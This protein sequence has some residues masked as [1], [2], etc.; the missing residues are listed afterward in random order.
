MQ[1]A[2]RIRELAASAALFAAV[3]ALIGGPLLWGASRHLP[4]VPADLPPSTQ[5]LVRAVDKRPFT[6]DAPVSQDW[7]KASP[8]VTVFCFSGGRS[9][10]TSEGWLLADDLLLS[11]HTQQLWQIPW[12]LCVFRRDPNPGVVTLEVAEIPVET[13]TT[14]PEGP[15]TTLAHPE[16]PGAPH[17]H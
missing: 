12:E 8:Y 9:V 10:F 4:L 11:N 3:A 7:M 5:L 16:A 14:V 1:K 6:V 15:S 17:A 2:K 13:S